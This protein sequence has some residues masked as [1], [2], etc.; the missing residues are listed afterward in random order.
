MDIIRYVIAVAIG[1]FVVAV[2]VPV[3]L[4]EIANA[5]LTGVNAAVATI[6]TVLLP[7]LAVIGIA[8][9]FLPGGTKGK[10]GL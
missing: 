5:N 9:A 2:I 3:A 1:I 10:I 8:I 6:L 7:I 4:V